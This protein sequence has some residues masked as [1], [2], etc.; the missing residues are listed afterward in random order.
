[1]RFKSLKFRLTIWYFMSFFVATGIIFVSFYITTR[2]TLYNHTDSLLS[3]HSGKIRDIILRNSEL[4]HTASDEKVLNQEFVE[5]PGMV[6]VIINE[7]GEI[8]GGSALSSKL[9]SMFT[10]FYTESISGDI[11]RYENGKIGISPTRFIIAPLY[12]NSSFLGTLIVG[13]PIEVIDNSLRSLVWE[14]MV[15]FF[16]LMILSIIGGYLI[17]KQALLP[18]T[19]VSNMMRSISHRNL[20]DRVVNPQ[21]RDEMEGLALAFNELL[22]RLSDAFKRERQFISDIAHELK[23]PLAILKSRIEI[24]I[25]KNRSAES[26]KKDLAETLNDVDNLTSTVTGVLDLAWSESDNAMIQMDKINLSEIIRE[27]AEI[28]GSLARRKRI[29]IKSSVEPDIFIFGKKDKI[30]QAIINVIENAIK[31]TD[32]EGKIGVTLKSDSHDA[33]LKIKDDGIGISKKDLPYIF[34]RFYRATSKEKIQGTG[35]G[36]AIVKSIVSTHNGVI[37]ASSKINSGTE[38]IIKLPL[39]N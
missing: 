7:N 30:S 36:L 19:E 35:L 12:Q 13:H 37:K 27:L 24:S 32:H 5:M 33:V 4:M 28:A 23:T 1:M 2:Q 34:D 11:P 25:T 8:I 29:N 15:V 26:Y 10:R 6:V 3:D 22:D 18:I 17:A 9:N 38:I 20:D 39:F 21:T 16:I 31:Y 14:L